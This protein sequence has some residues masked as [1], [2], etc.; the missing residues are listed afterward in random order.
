MVNTSTQ[1]YKFR[2]FVT[3]E[4]LRVIYMFGHELDYIN[5]K[6]FTTMNII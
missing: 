6:L 2:N 3:H 1:Y 5:D 4:Y